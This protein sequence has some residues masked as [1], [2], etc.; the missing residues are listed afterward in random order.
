MLNYE[1]GSLSSIGSIQPFV[2][3]M[4]RKGEFDLDEL[5]S[6]IPPNSENISQPKVI[7][8]ENS[9][10]KQGGTVI[11]MDYIERVRRIADRHN[12]KLHL[13][14]SRMFNALVHLDKEIAEV[15][16]YFDSISLGLT[17]GLGCP[18][19][20]MLISNQDFI[21]EAKFRRKMIGGGMRQSGV[22]SI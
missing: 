10:C 9:V 7:C 1:G 2:L 18:M 16:P 12:L 14:G 4:D 11:S 20:S 22:M 19:G 6:V 13:D 15:S 8:L 17:R 5:E 21:H 3:K